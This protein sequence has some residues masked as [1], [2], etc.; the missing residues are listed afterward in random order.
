MK[1]KTLLFLFIFV[2]GSLFAQ[3]RGIK[4]VKEVTG[5]KKTEIENNYYA[6][7]IGNN[8]YT[9]PEISSL[10]EPINDAKKL[11]NV[12]V[13]NYM[14]AEKN[15]TLIKNATYLQIIEA[16]D[17]LSK[18]ITE[19]DNLLIFY[20]GHG[21]WNE[22]K[23]LGYWFPVNA[24]KN[25]TAFWIRNSTISDYM[26]SINSKHTLL[27]ADACFSGGIFKTRVPFTDAQQAIKKLYA[28]P[29]RTAMTSGNLKEVPDNSVFLKYLV[30]RLIENKNKY[31]SADQLFASFRIAVMDNS[32]TEPQF[33]TIKNS[34]SEGGEFIF[35]KRTKTN[36]K[37]T[38]YT[39]EEPKTGGL[40]KGKTV[41]KYG[42]ISINTEIGGK[43]YL[44]DK[45]MGTI[46]ENTS[47]NILEKQ[48]TGS[49]TYKIVGTDET[50]TGNITVYEN[51]TA[52]IEI[53]SKNDDFTVTDAGLNIKMRGIQGGKFTMGS[54]DSDASSNETP[55]TVTVSNFEIMKYEVTFAEYD[56]FCDATGRGKPDDE[57]WGRGS[58]PVI[59]VSW[60]DAVAYAKW[61]SKKTGK[62][63]RLPTEAEWEYAAKGGENYK[64]AGSNNIDSIAWYDKNS[65][66]KGSSHADYGTHPVGT[67]SP[68]GYGFYDM[69][70]NVCEWCS[71]WYGSYNTDA[72]NNTKGASSGSSRVLR[73]GGW[74]NSAGYCRVA[75]RSS[76]TP[77]N[78][79]NR[80]GF[81]LAETN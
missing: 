80:I 16:F 4:P 26:A 45:Y 9:D 37:N 29:S 2:T 50:K 41:Y 64:Y 1:T 33:G 36:N 77:D 18:T 21:W 69:T 47:D 39:H 48:L 24:K 3:E 53:K 55:H 22:K 23:K 13:K 20:A 15:V 42:D 10:D 54:N 51:Q 79:S 30:K 65:Y 6:L 81:R 17:N 59:N 76:S 61:L 31:L 38:D 46:E 27:I 78:R 70:G 71:D 25:S 35:I 63:W 66:Y 28:L 7:I 62:T 74:I 73:G 72:Q 11:Y 14:F 32:D 60:H 56:K 43:I 5:Q 52:Y 44:D 58:R 8:I 12:L 68:N 49:H 57:G 34:G 19:N 67:K 40:K 75:Y